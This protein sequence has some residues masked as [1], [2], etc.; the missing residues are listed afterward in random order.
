[1]KSYSRRIQTSW[2]KSF[3]WISVCYSNHKIYCSTRRTAKLCGRLTFSKHKSAF[4]DDGF[5]NLKEALER[6]P[7]HERSV[8]HKEALKKWQPLNL[9]RV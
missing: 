9:C 8:M 2:Y 3:S 5:K 7:E 1:M 6:F 4:V